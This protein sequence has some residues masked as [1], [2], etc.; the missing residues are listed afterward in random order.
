MS[1]LAKF[2][3]YQKA[4]IIQNN[5]LVDS[6][7]YQSGPLSWPLMTR[8]V[9]YWTDHV[10]KYQIYM[11]GNVAGW[12]GGLVCIFIFCAITVL[13]M[14]LRKRGFRLFRESKLTRRKLRKILN[15]SILI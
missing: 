13:D 1:F 6:H 2:V 14:G 5:N 8:G 7:P 10:N 9:N 11:T 12:W 15:R 3:E 4:M